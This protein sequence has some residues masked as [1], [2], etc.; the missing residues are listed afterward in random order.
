MTFD[1][2]AFNDGAFDDI[3]DELFPAIF[4]YTRLRVCSSEVE[5]VTADVMVRIWQSLDSFEGRGSLKAWAFAIASR[6]VADYY[7]KGGSK[8]VELAP[9]SDGVA[10]ARDLVEDVAL[11]FAVS[12]VMA[13]LSEPQAAVIQ[14]R[15]V[16]GL[17]AEQT[18]SLLGMSRQAVDSLLYRA[19]KKFQAL[20]N[21]VDSGIRF[22]GA[23][24]DV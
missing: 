1:D 3:Y 22:S 23:G 5:D 12:D 21:H 15:L 4:R 11:A 20:Y 17:D 19:R 16:E 18:A 2:S 8:K 10:E 7:R 9:L 13:R 14:M 24:G 6:T